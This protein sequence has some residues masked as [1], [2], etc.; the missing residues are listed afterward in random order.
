M[1]KKHKGSLSNRY[2]CVRCGYN[3]NDKADYELHYGSD[4]HQKA[5]SD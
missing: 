1:K 4:E 2:K 3:T 5:I